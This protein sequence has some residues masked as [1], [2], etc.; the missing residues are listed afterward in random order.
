MGFVT[1]YN[2][3]KKKTIR[4]KIFAAIALV[5]YLSRRLNKP[6]RR[7][8]YHIIILSFIVRVTRAWDRTVFRCVLSKSFLPSL[9]VSRSLSQTLIFNFL[10]I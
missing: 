6:K 10:Y 8:Y 1:F 9:S 3:T 7:K 5:N 4:T 2:G